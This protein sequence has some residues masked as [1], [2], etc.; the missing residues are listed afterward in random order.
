M[1]TAKQSNENAAPTQAPTPIPVPA[2]IAVAAARKFVTLT[3]ETPIQRGEQTITS[4]QLMKPRTGD[5]RG[6]SL[7][8]VSMMKTDAVA[9][10]LLRITV[11]SLLKHEVAEMDV[12]D[13]INCAVEITGFFASKADMASPTA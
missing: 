13:L 6:L 9:E 10:L 2:A 8:E 3:L 4:I 1:S 11:P 5:L 7:G 12:A